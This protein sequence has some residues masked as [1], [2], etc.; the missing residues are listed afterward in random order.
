[1]RPNFVMFSFIFI[2]VIVE[3]DH[4]YIFYVCVFA[5][6][7]TYFFISLTHFVSTYFKN[8]LHVRYISFSHSLLSNV[9]FALRTFSIS[10]LHNLNTLL[11]FGNVVILL[12]FCNLLLSLLLNAVLLF[13]GVCRLWSSLLNACCNFCKF[14]SL[15]K[16]FF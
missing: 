3:I 10:L 13:S 7:F 1:M 2:N 16:H 11:L 15:N 6:K 8:I 9:S 14:S 4:L 5:L 12:N